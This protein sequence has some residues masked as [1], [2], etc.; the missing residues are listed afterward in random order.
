[1]KTAAPTVTDV[2]DRHLRA[3]TIEPI[4]THLYGFTVPSAGVEA[5]IRVLPGRTVVDFGGPIPEAVPVSLLLR[6]QSEK[7]GGSFYASAEQLDGFLKEA[8]ASA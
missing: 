1:M 7:F 4:A 3:G 6:A 2:V 5:T 8:S